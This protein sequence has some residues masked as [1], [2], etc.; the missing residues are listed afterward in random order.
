[1][2]R[3][4][5]AELRGLPKMNLPLAQTLTNR[6]LEKIYDESIWSFQLQESGW[7][8]PGIVASP[9]LTTT[10]GGTI[11]TLFASNQIVGDAAA[12]AAWAAIPAKF[13][14]TNMQIRLPAYAIYSVIAQAVNTPSAGLTT[15]TIDRPWM[16][17]DGADLSYMMYQCYYPAPGPGK[18]KRWLAVRDFTN[19]AY[20]NWKISTQQDLDS[21]DPQRTIFQNPNR[22]VPYKIDTRPGSSTLGTML[23]ELY[24]QPL[25][26][27]PYALY[28]VGD[29][30]SLSNPTDAVPPPL[31]DEVTLYRAKQQAYIWCEENKGRYP[32]LGKSDWEFLAKASGELYKDR[33]KDIRKTDRDL[34]DAFVSTLRRRN[35][36]VGGP[37]YSAVTG[38]ANVG[39]F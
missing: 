34:A 32:E 4:I 33:I 16:E 37:F 29:P 13:L 25:S 22:V 15:L 31:T 8:T 21:E 35:I 20:L 10:S 1:M 36:T 3:D 28:F 5:T 19:G 26:Q 30:A 12:S 11:T 18:F 7:F 17:P 6:A 38:Q 9:P 27:L 24:P 2:F 39:A 14:I 23:F